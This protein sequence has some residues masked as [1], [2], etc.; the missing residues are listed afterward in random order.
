MATKTEQQNLINTNLASGIS[1]PAVDHREVELS[2]V[3]EIYGNIYVGGSLIPIS[4]YDNIINELTPNLRTNCIF[5]KNGNIL[6]FF[7]EIT[8]STGSIIGLTDVF[9][10]SNYFQVLIGFPQSCISNSKKITFSTN[11]MT[12]NRLSVGEI[13]SFDGQII[14]ND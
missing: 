4:T 8:N 6:S 7:I 2:L 11:K 14:L 12:I 9:E 13:I 1:I 10:F 3:D 5:S